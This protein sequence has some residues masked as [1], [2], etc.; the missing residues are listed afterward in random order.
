MNLIERY[1]LYFEYYPESVHGDYEL[2]VP[3]VKADV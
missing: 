1:S 3:V 2:W